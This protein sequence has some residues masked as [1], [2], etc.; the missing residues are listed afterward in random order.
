MNNNTHAH[1]DFDS[2]TIRYAGYDYSTL[3]LSLEL[4]CVCSPTNLYTYTNV[5]YHVF[6][7]L[8]EA[9]SKGKFFN[10]FIKNN[11]KFKK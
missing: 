7:G 3:E 6:N 1:Y 4:L 2:S 11:F 9:R 8:V 10:Q 5:P